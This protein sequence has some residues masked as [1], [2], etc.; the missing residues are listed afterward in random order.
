MLTADT[1]AFLIAVAMYLFLPII[2]GFVQ[3]PVASGYGFG[4]SILTS[5]LVFVPLFRRVLRGQSVPD[6]VHQPVRCPKHDPVR[7]GRLRGVHPVLRRRT[8][9]ALEAFVAAGIAGIGIGFTFAA[10]PGFIIVAVP[11]SE[12]GSAMGLYQVLRSIGLSLGSALAAAVLI[13]FTKSGETY[14][15]YEGFRVTLIIATALC[16]STAVLSFLLPVKSAGTPT[17][18]TPAIKE[19]MREEAVVEGAGG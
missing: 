18:P 19:L 7:F 16:L 12:T 11:A 4:A 1:S 15:T 6:R 2:V 8:P 17:P 9:G 5:G 13:S 10:M 14:P 3:I